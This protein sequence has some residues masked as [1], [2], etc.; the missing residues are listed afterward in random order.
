MERVDLL[1]SVGLR[2]GTAETSQLKNYAPENHILVGFDD[3]RDD[4]Y[5][6]EDQIVADPK[7]FLTALLERL[8]GESR[9]P[10]EERKRDIA[11]CKLSLKEHLHAQMKEFRSAKP[12][13]SWVF[14]GDPRLRPR[15]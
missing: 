8:K 2:A 15:S 7:L 10:D 4:A 13:P 6:G 14:D 3:A 1:L 12:D 11:A 5:T 9:P